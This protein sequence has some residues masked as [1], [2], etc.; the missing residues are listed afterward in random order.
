MDLL[1]QLIIFLILLGAGYFWG[2]RAEK[3]HYRSII[4]RE[5]TNSDILII[6]T[7]QPPIG[8][9][10]GD[11]VLGSVVIAS[12][13]FKN[14]VAWLVGIFGGRINVY[15]SLLDRARREAVLRM[16]DEARTH[17]ANMI[18]NMKFETATLNNIQQGKSAMVEVLAYGTAV[19]HQQQLNDN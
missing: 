9:K 3:K 19:K 8:S 14:F 5:K 17:G 1:I 4:E 18:V 11:L 13:Y 16:K 15:E 12:D 2:T 7:K 6:A 10:D